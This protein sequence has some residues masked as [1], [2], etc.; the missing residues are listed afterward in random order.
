M[1]SLWVV[2]SAGIEICQ[3]MGLIVIII[4]LTLEC[5]GISPQLI[6]GLLLKH[7]LTKLN[8]ESRF[9]LFANHVAILILQVH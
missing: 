5:I 1:S 8:I 9:F 4:L 7:N 6:Y 2:Y 3:Y